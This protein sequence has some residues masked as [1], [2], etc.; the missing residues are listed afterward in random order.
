MVDYLTIRVLEA[1]LIYPADDYAGRFY[2]CDACN[3]VDACCAPREDLV[4]D[5]GCPSCG[6]AQRPISPP[7]VPFSGPNR[8][9]RRATRRRR[10]P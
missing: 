9:E 3:Q 4:D 6:A 5:Y 1:R 2:W 10:R 7:G 8:C